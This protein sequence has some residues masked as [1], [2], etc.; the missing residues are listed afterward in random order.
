MLSIEILSLRRRIQ[1]LFL[2]FALIAVLQYG[3]DRYVADERNDARMRIDGELQPARDEVSAILTALI[4]QETGQ[5]GYVITGDERFLEPYETGRLA[6][7]RGLMRLRELVGDQPSLLAGIERIESRISAWRQIGAEFEIRA[8]RLGRDEEA[9]ALVATGTGRDLFD[10]ARAELAGVRTQLVGEL[11]AEQ[12]HV[13]RLRRMLDIV[14]A[15]GFAVTLFLVILAGLLLRQWITLPV[16]RLSVAVRKVADGRLETTIPG[17]GPPDLACLGE[18]VEGMRRRLLAEID[19]AVR[20]REALMKR[21]MVVLT[22]RDE[23]APR[24]TELPAGVSVA[25]RLEPAEGVLAGDWYDVVPTSGGCLTVVLV[26]VSG[27]ATESGVFAVKTKHLAL[28][29]LE[30]G[31]SPGEALAWLADRLGDTGDDF[32]TGVIVELDPRTGRLRYAS[33][34]HPPMLVAT[35]DGVIELSATG[36]LLGPLPATWESEEIELAPGD[37]IAIYS[38]GLVDAQDDAR[39]EFGTER[40]VAE[41]RKRDDGLQAV[42]DRVLAS[43]QRFHPGRYKDDVTLLLAGWEP[44]ARLGS[45]LGDDLV[46][47]GKEIVG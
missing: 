44:S 7:D 25:A 39:Q 36:P 1:L 30:D 33:A 5:R 42:A 13:D 34:G 32:L 20:A 38:D 35:D 45:G 10:R 27:H 29:A 14:S 16:A 6:V 8:K 23:L 28:A 4:D 40:L 3:A 43:L 18:D 24:R 26:D 21:G 17:E 22:L 41:L 2:G 19:D 9:V 37:L 47:L 11:V 31:R 12:E 15:V 46:G